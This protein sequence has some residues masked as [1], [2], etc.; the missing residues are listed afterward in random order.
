MQI[1]HVYV[2]MLMRSV[3]SIFHGPAFSASIPLMVPERHLVRISGIGFTLNG[4]KGIIGPGLGALCMELLPLHGIMLIDV[5]T[6][7]LAIVPLLILTIPQPDAHHVERIRS[8]SYFS[9]LKEG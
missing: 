1:W 6:A 3:G 4:I 2:V 9:N 5:F 8:V 7:I